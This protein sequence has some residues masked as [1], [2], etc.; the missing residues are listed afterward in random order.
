MSNR[1]NRWFV[2]QP[3]VNPAIAIVR[4][5]GAEV[6]EGNEVVPRL[7]LKTTTSR[8]SQSLEA[9]PFPGL[10]EDSFHITMLR[11]RSDNKDDIERYAAK[12]R[13]LADALLIDTP[14]YETPESAVSGLCT[15]IAGECELFKDSVPIV[16]TIT[17]SIG[18]RYMG[19]NDVT[20]QPEMKPGARFL[21]I[22]TIDVE[23]SL[24]LFTELHEE[25]EDT[26]F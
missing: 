22:L 16:A 6:R 25:D 14:G 11:A 13:Y 24:Q 26:P 7:R 19:V 1:Q 20:G 2:S 4:I 23:T 21:S 18:D 17:T 15:V 10:P 3:V 5:H 9:E 12:L 8:L